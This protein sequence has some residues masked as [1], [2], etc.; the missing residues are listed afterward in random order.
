EDGIR[1]F[2]VTGVQTCALPIWEEVIIHLPPPVALVCLSATVSNAEE[3]AEWLTTVRGDTRLILEERRPVELEHLCLVG[4]RQSERPQI[5][6][7]ACR[8]RV[9]IA[10][11][12][13]RA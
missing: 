11:G 2:H 6:R 1:D 5:G 9:R 7:A 13:V 12:S 3:V 4:D 8:E 10:G